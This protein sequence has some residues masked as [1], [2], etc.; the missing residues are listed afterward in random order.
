[1]SNVRKRR[2]SREQKQK[3]VLKYVEQ[4]FL[5][6]EVLRLLGKPEQEEDY[7]STAWRYTEVWI[8]FTRQEPVRVKC[9]INNGLTDPSLTTPSQLCRGSR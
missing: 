5:P 1:M 3:D 9:I 6:K 4:D 8:V 7:R 2:A